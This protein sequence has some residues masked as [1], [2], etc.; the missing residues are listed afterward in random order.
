MP[1]D[2]ALRGGSPAAGAVY[3]ALIRARQTEPDDFIFT[4][5]QVDF[6]LTRLPR[7]LAILTSTKRR[8]ALLTLQ[9]ALLKGQGIDVQVVEE[10]EAI[11]SPSRVVER[12]LTGS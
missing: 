2:V 5:G 11:Q 8:A 7:G 1:T 12:L 9:E 4:G 3:T 10:A 6:V